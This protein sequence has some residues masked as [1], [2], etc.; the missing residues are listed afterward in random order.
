MSD[1]VWPAWARQDE[2]PIAVC[3]DGEYLRRPDGEEFIRA[4]YADGTVL[5]ATGYQK[6]HCWTPEQ[7]RQII[8]ALDFPG[9]DYE[10]FGWVIALR[11]ANNRRDLER[12]ITAEGGRMTR[13][14][15][16]RHHG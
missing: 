9:D 2:A 10:R 12:A 1:R 7:V 13:A 16:N 11:L 6:A 4:V 5:T 15:L 8:A 3:G 14:N